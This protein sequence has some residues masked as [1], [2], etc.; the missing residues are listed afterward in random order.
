MNLHKPN[1]SDKISQE[2]ITINDINR[3]KRKR[4]ENINVFETN[5]VLSESETSDLA[6]LSEN[7][8]QIELNGL[9]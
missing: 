4:D 5:Q 8:N 9:E 3:S 6:Y 1:S 7:I 2:K